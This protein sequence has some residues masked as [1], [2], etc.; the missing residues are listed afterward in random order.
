MKDEKACP[1]GGY[2]KCN[3][4]Y[5]EYRYALSEVLHLCC[6]VLN[7]IAQGDTSQKID[8]KFERY[9]VQRLIDSINKLSEEVEALVN[10]THELAVGICEH[11]D[12]LRRLYLGDFS[13]QASEDSSIEIVRMLGQLINKQKERFLDYINKIKEQY[14]EIQKLY[15]Q[16]RVI[17]SSLGVA[18]I[19]VEE[20]MTIEFCN[21]EFERLTGYS[22]KEI[23]GKMQWTT[24]FSEKMLD[25]MI[26][27]HKL[28]R[29]DPS[30]AP[31]QYESL[32][33]DR[34]G[35][36]K[37]V[38]INVGMIPYTKKSIASII[39]ISER[40]KIQQQLI[41]S[42]KMESLGF[43]SGRVAHEYNN[44]LTGILGFAELLKIKIE[45][46]TAKSYV[47]KIV[48]AAERAKELSRKL[49]IFGRK[50]EINHVEKISL[51]KYLLEFYDFAKTIIGRDIEFVLDLPDE[52]LFYKID[53]SHLEVVIINL[54]TNTRDAMPEGGK[55]T[56]GLKKL[57]LDLDYTF[58]HPLVKPGNY[59]VLCVSD[60][61]VGMD[62]TTK[63]RLFEPFFTTKP[64]GKGTGL[65]LST[66]YGIVK[67][68][69]GHIHVY[70]ELGKGTTFK[71][72]LPITSIREN[73][74]D[75]ES[76][77]GKETILVIDDNEQVRQFFVSILKEFGYTVLESSSGK[78]GLQLFSENKDLIALALVDLVMPGLSGLEVVKRI[79]QIKPEQKV[80]IMSGYPVSFKDIDTVE[81]NL[82]VEEI[83]YKIR[84]ILDKER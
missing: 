57:H 62:E 73:S 21:E 27:Y 54:I 61:G 32:L 19:V 59:I 51:N 83:L 66:V 71:I 17:L 28:R 48:D 53:P 42:Q 18:I 4:P 7:K 2:L 38:L 76:L 65:G 30:L 45:E 37:E 67:Q 49:L 78:E 25:K 35:N 11:F 39:D 46:P 70:S 23:E 22:K 77:K 1:Y 15:E 10:L 20:D 14:E 5:C 74:I 31:K 81:K 47:Q 36:I 56:I 13:A 82:S 40:K 12:V 75:K 29:I 3:N 52:E 6:D 63:Q 50:E 34:D 72:Y 33:K 26:K 8:L 79:R 44:I 43:L 60:T 41:H 68:Y 64:K 55:L 84:E 58:T 24:F 9:A 80:I 69:E 16:E